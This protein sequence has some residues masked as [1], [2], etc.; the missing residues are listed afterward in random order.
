MREIPIVTARHHAVDQLGLELFE[1]TA[2]FPGRHRTTQLIR[3]ACAESGRDHGEFDHLF[4][5]DRNAERAL[6]N[7]ADRIRS[8]R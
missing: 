6:E 4:L 1:T 5:E 8:S 7:A 3:F 2:T